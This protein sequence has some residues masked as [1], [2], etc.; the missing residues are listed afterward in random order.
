[1]TLGGSRIH[2]PR[3]HALLATL[4]ALLLLSGQLT[5]AKRDFFLPTHGLGLSIS[6]GERWRQQYQPLRWSPCNCLTAFACHAL[7]RNAA[8]RRKLARHCC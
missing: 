2:G 5:V 7:H 4:Y 6:V 8:C 1:M 3:G